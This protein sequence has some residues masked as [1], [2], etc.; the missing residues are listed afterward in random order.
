M[1]GY[2]LEYVAAEY[3]A[4]AYLAS[5]AL[6]VAS[7]PKQGAMSFAPADQARSSSIVAARSRCIS[8][9]GAPR[10]EQRAVNSRIDF[11]V[12]QSAKRS[13]PSTA[14][15]ASVQ[16]G[17]LLII[18]L[19]RLNLDVVLRKLIPELQ[20][21]S[22]C[23]HKTSMVRSYSSIYSDDKVFIRQ[24][25]CDNAFHGIPHQ[26]AAAHRTKSECPG[27]V[28]DNVKRNSIRL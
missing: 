11:S 9:R 6:T 15:R 3:A 17:A 8:A 25:S 12:A 10:N 21:F 19:H 14:D 4:D 22:E 1:L 16:S 24:M 26:I 23:I 5:V 13:N 2:V 18:R 7:H 28:P 20:A 27:S